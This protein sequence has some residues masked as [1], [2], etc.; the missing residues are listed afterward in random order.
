MPEADLNQ[1]TTE[2]TQRRMQFAARLYCCASTG[3]LSSGCQDVMD[4]LKQSADSHGIAERIEIVP[5]GCMG[6]CSL[7]P[8]IRVEVA[9]QEPVLYKEVTPLI[10]RLIL[11]EHVLPAITR[12]GS[13]SFSVPDYFSEYV[14]P[15]DLPFFQRQTKVVLENSGVVDPER[16]EDYIAR[17]G[18]AALRRV[19]ELHPRK[20]IEELGKSQL[21]G[22]GGGGFPTAKKWE[23]CRISP[24][25]EKFIICNGDEG[26]PG[27]YMDRSILEGNPHAVLEGMLIAAY[28][29]GA[30]EGWFYIRAEYP[31]AVQ[32]VQKALQQ[33]RKFK[34]LGKGILGSTFAFD[35]Q[36]RLG[37]G[38]FVC[39][40]E[41]ALIH[42]VE[43]QRG[44]P[45]PRPPY[46]S[47][48]GLWNQPS[49]VNN[50]ETLA[51]VP[52]IF[53]R[54]AEWFASMGTE[55]SKGTKV[56]ALTG[57]V[58]H[59]GLIE[60]PM[61]MSL[62][63]IVDV[64]GGGHPEGKTLKAV[65]T[66]GPS[67]GVIPTDV[68]DT[69]VCYE[70]LKNLGSM[71]GSGG[72]IVMDEDDSMVEIAKFYLGFTVEESCGK[73][74]PCRI[75]GT[76]MLGLLTKVSEGHATLDDLDLLKVL[77]HA[78]KKAS[79]CGL[80]QT[81]PNPV[82]SSLTY[83]ESE[84]MDKVIAYSEGMETKGWLPR[85]FKAEVE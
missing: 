69:P 66:G 46:P 72:M 10:A 76:Q 36:I 32:R 42:S 70:Q 54:G 53:T 27:A 45:R 29:T 77:A 39:G 11:A 85:Q 52:A 18:Y 6:L 30:T 12:E 78:M 22:R 4:A 68:L 50:V 82:I 79:L 83:F 65:Q 2:E 1:I 16:I 84:Y 58:R 48:Q 40:E 25:E 7:G 8:L 71:M 5:T 57:K 3:C 9:G 80:G 37:A 63:D 24:G 20:V 81:A 62:R 31:L 67:G 56:F 64:I 49:C 55:T 41:T 26:D 75:G 38:A 15:M 47:V 23:F 28:A 73:C 19:V 43:G 44:T 74:A 61:G 59:S 34:L 21:R 35:A 17:G 14:L 13:G 60:V 33:A 51:N